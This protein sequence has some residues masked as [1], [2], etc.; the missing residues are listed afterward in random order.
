VVDG[1]E[2]AHGEADARL[3]LAAVSLVL[4]PGRTVRRLVGGAAA[5]VLFVSTCTSGTTT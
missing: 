5:V 1:Q 4:L 3:G 2:F